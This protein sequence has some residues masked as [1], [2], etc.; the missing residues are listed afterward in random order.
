MTILEKPP[1]FDLQRSKLVER[2]KIEMRTLKKIQKVRQKADIEWAVDLLLDPQSKSFMS[3]MM[4]HLEAEPRSLFFHK[5]SIGLEVCFWLS[6]LGFTWTNRNEEAETSLEAL[7]Q[8]ISNVKERDQN[9]GGSST[10]AVKLSLST[11]PPGLKTEKKY[12]AAA[13]F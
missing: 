9:R 13:G 2:K 7:L 11:S 10:V 4:H 5:R 6:Q 12:L 3:L 8:A 1:N